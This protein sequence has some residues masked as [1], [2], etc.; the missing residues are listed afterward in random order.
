MRSEPPKSLERVVGL[1]LPPARREE[2]LGDLYEKCETP[3]RYVS[4]A[5]RVVPAVILSRIRRTSDAQTLVMG[6][7]LLY[8]SFLGAAWFTD[9]SLLNDQ[10]MFWRL[11]VPVVIA[12]VF[13]VFDDAWTSDRRRNPVRLVRGAV[14]GLGAGCVFV[15]GSMPLRAVMLGCAAGLLM[16]SGVRILFPAE[17]AKLQR[18]SGPPLMTAKTTMNLVLAAVGSV[19]IAVVL[20]GIGLKPGMAA[21]VIFLAAVSFG[22]RMR[23]E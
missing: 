6:A 22:S 13:L 9:R 14:L 8:M 4:T 18:V 15:T 20:V 12:L 1:L 21:V 16:I 3:R 10:R 5:A 19:G 23:K 7:L 11:A 17:T 2:V